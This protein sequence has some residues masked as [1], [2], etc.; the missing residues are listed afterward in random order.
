MDMEEAVGAELK[1]CRR[2]K[3][4]SQEQLAFD[5]GVHRTYVSLI[6]RGSKTPTALFASSSR[7]TSHGSRL[8]RRASALPC[9]N[10]AAHRPLSIGFRFPP[11]AYY[12][13]KT[14]RSFSS[15]VIPLTGVTLL[16]FE[17]VYAWIRI[18]GTKAG[19]R[20]AQRSHRFPS[21]SSTPMLG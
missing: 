11:P 8:F 16:T 21:E 6:E 20:H 2:K 13:L 4:I 10:T 7:P 19:G 5:A 17:R 9:S 18:A 14:S 1:A 3:Q 12:S 15:T